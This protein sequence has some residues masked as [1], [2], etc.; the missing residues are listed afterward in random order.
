VQIQWCKYKININEFC[1][2]LPEA[3]LEA[4]VLKQLEALGLLERKDIIVGNALNKKIS[5]GQRKRL[6]IALE[7]IREP[8]VLFV[9][10]PTSGLSSRDSENVMD[11]LK[12]LTLKG[13]LIF[14]V[15]H[16]PSSDIYKMFDK[17][18][19]LDTGGYPIY[20]GNPIEAVMYFKRAAKQANSDVGECHICGSVNPELLFNIIE[21]KEVDEYGTYTSK[22]KVQPE[23]WNKL[24]NEKIELPVVPEIKTLPGKIFNIP[25]RIKQMSVFIARD[26]FSKLSNKQYLLINFL[27]APLLAFILSFIVRYYENPESDEYIFRLNENVPAYI[28]MSIIVILFI[29]L[30][31]SA[32]EI[33]KDQRIL[34][35]ERLLNLSRFSYLSS[36]L[37]ILFSLSAIQALLFVL[38]GNSVI[39]LKGMFLSY[40][41]MLFS[42]SCC[43]NL[44]GLNISSTFNS[45]V[46]IY[47]IIPILLIPQMILGGAMFSFEKLNIWIGGSGIKPP[48][49]S[50][51]MISRWAYEGLMVNQ[52]MNNKFDKAFYE[53]EQKVALLNF[54]QVYFLPALLKLEN[55]CSH[56][57]DDHNDNYKNKFSILMAELH[58]E[59]DLTKIN[60]GYIGKKE[61]VV[62]SKPLGDSIV[63]YIDKLGNY[64]TMLFNKADEER[65]GYIASFQKTNEDILLFKKIKNEYSNESVTDIVKNKLT[66]NKISVNEGRLCQQLYSVYVEP[67]KSLFS[68]RT[69]FMAPLKYFFTSRLNTFAFNVIIIWLMSLCFFITLYFDVLKKVFNAFSKKRFAVPADLL[70]KVTVK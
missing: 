70:S 64:Y 57:F 47:I 44:I 30:T 36:K 24:F 50:D 53:Q 67:D 43:A 46:T 35:R 39:G 33:Y 8:L 17:L 20:Y 58:R 29:G 61:Q 60:L 56:D 40:W 69:H 65:N 15:I 52:F 48:V 18:V 16:Q 1:K 62:F 3:E 14:V 27:E 45:A 59:A 31:V 51:L 22:R 12:E 41:L 54:K 28:F 32:E 6:N 9:D 63:S 38:V 23:Q 26:L 7:L 4:K 21:S 2:N 34:K 66:K 68:V 5:G 19:L 10:E 25:G 55:E 49:V 13:K 11:L 42:V 37:V